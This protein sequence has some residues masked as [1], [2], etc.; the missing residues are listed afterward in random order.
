VRFEFLFGKRLV[1][2]IQRRAGYIL[3]IIYVCWI[4]FFVL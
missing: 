2:S 1:N 4:L 3:I